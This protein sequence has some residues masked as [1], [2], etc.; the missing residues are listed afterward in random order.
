MMWCWEGS[1][2][3]NGCCAGSC[4]HVW[5][6]AQA[7]PY[8]FPALERT[9][10][11]AELKHSM[12]RR[13]HV[14]FR[15]TLP[16][17]AAEHGFHAAC[18]G[19]LGGVMK[20]YR[21]WQIGGD[22]RW[23]KA[24]YPL[25]RRSLEYCIRTWDPVRRGALVEPHHNT[26]D[27]EFWGPDIMCTGFYLGALRAM[28]EMATAV[29]R[30]EDARQYSALA[31]KG[32]AFCDARLWN[33]DYYCQR[34]EWK[35]LKSARQLR[36]LVEGAG[37]I[38]AGGGYSA[39]AMEIFKREGPKYQYGAG[40]ISDGVMGQGLTTQLGLPDALN[41]SRT[42]RHLKAIFRHNFRRTL[43]GHANPQ[44]PGYALNDEPGLLLCSWPR[45][46]KPSLPFVY[47]DEVWTGIEYQVASHMIWEGLVAEGLSIV[48]AV[49]ERYEG[50]VRNPWN[51]YECGNYYARA[52]A[53]YGLLLA[54]GGFRYHAAASRLELAPRLPHKNGRLFFSVESG[55]GSID[56]SRRGRKLTVRIRVEEGELSVE[57]VVFS[58]ALAGRRRRKRSGGTACPHR[59]LTIEI[60][61]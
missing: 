19:Q 59:P 13:G 1:S 5:N 30:D 4:T 32:K 9:M 16:T 14:A 41:R 22:Q 44:R 61:G 53:S 26:Y 18:D 37:Q 21:E 11:D 55:W 45:G 36:R 28:A 33:G 20:V 51:E 46:G 17:G 39:E 49:R 54:L 31:E 29:G 50:G 25:A 8:L 7:L 24:R 38:H 57:E 27:I 40:C 10:R 34:V 3:D 60:G 12:D 42:R 43:R 6:Y 58:G 2:Y 35:N 23:L 15:S 47:S 56:Y 48:R 52:M